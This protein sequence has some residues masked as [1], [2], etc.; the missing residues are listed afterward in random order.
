MRFFVQEMLKN[1]GNSLEGKTCVVSGSGNVAQ[2]T[3]EK[4]IQLGGKVVT[5]S[6]SSGTIVDSDGIS[7]EKLEFVKELKMNVAAELRN[8]QIS[9]DVNF[10]KGR[11]HG[12]C[13]VMSPS[14]QRLKMKSP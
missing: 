1:K 4:V 13:L 5:L 3:T 6:D 9:L 14:L 10:W 12:R 7:L 8:M 2:Y 11:N